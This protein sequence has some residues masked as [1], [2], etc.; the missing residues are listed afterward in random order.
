MRLNF[1]I[2]VIKILKI[3]YFNFNQKILHFRG[4]VIEVKI[5][6]HIKLNHN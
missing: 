5:E 6:L 1:Q 4:T 2:I 3:L